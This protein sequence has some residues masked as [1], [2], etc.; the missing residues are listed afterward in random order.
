MEQ[1]K[2]KDIDKMSEGYSKKEKKQIKTFTHI[3]NF[4]IKGINYTKEEFKIK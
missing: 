3:C 1:V 4:F 2:E